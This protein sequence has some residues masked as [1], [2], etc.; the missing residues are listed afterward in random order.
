MFIDAAS[1]AAKS[2]GALVIVADGQ[3][4]RK[5]LE[6]VFEQ[7]KQV[8]AKLLGIAYNFVQHKEKD[9]YNKYYRYS[10]QHKAERRATREMDS[11]REDQQE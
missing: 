11:E 8:N 1:L 6:K 4:D 10:T 5:N 7:L 9:Y 2:D 3:V